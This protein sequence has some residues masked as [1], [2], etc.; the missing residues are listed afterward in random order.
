MAR[1]PKD[2]NKFPDDEDIESSVAGD[3]DEESAYEEEEDIE[4]EEELKEDL[5]S[6]ADPIY[7]SVAEIKAML[8]SVKKQEIKDRLEF[9]RHMTRD[10]ANILIANYYRVQAQ[11]KRFKQQMKA[12]KEK[13]KQ[14]P[15]LKYNFDQFF[16]IEKENYRTL[17]IYSSYNPAGIWLRSIVG[18]GPVIAMGLISYLDVSK[19]DYAGSFLR[20]A[21]I[22]AKIK[23]WGKEEASGF[24]NKAVEQRTGKPLAKKLLDTHAISEEEARLT[25]V[26]GDRNFS[27]LEQY[28]RRMLNITDPEEKVKFTVKIVR[29]FLV[30]P[31]WNRQLKQMCYFAGKSFC[32]CS[33]RPKSL[34]GKLYKERKAEETARNMDGEYKDQAAAILEDRGSSLTPSVRSQLQKGQLIKAHIDKRALRW[35]EKILLSHYFDL[36]YR[37]YHEGKEPPLPYAIGKL[38]HE[39]ARFI[40]PENPEIYEMVIRDALDISNQTGI[41]WL[42]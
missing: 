41:K 24:I 10:Q 31:P 6:Q 3:T 11:R 5:L 36:S 35:V 20:Y 39:H 30:M 21:G 2:N 37:V 4:A 40:E 12:F 16:T 1:S 32:Y 38:K 28:G 22:D 15:F 42:Y 33:N 7:T 27:A 9:S 19:A 34:Y 26:I 23:W 29:N 25:C 17:D 14:Y 18:I 8:G 13:D